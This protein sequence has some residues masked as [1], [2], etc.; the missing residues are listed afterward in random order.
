MSTLLVLKERLQQIYAKYSLYITK[1]VQF[2]FGLLLFGAINS[3][4]G[5]MKGASSIL[6]TVG[7]AVICAFL[8]M[9]VMVLAA[10]VLVLVHLYALSM[11]IAVVMAVIFVLMY[12]FYFRFTPQKAWVVL[13]AVLACAFKLPVVV[14]VMFGL[15]GTPV[16]IVPAA[17]G[18]I[19]YYLLHFV[20][21]SSTA[22]QGAD[23]GGMISGLMSFTKQAIGNK[24][25]WVMVLAL[26]ISL[27]VVHAIR[28]RSLDYS[29]KIAS[30]AGAVTAVIIGM[31]GN[32]TLHVHIS[33]VLLIGSGI[34]AVAVGLVLE[35]LFFSVDYSRTEHI[36]FEDDEYYYYVKAV[37][38]GRRT[39]KLE[40]NRTPIQESELYREVM[41]RKRSFD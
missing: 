17:C 18:V 31:A 38:K 3:N 22:L 13:V 21:E 28:T 35:F 34:A 14:P 16:Y 23:A 10:T 4:I 32:L 2:L 30:A 11:P 9:L 8:P 19:T 5:F 40:K 39:K 12:I 41:S 6:C 1:S 29:W 27:M 36:Q 26:V 33:Y 15:L 7:L 37:P 20:K 25:M 24:E